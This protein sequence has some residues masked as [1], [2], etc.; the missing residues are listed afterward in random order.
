MGKDLEEAEATIEGLIADKPIRPKGVKPGMNKVSRMI[1]NRRL[2]DGMLKKIAAESGRDHTKP[3][4]YDGI[5]PYV[6][7]DTLKGMGQAVKEP[8]ISGLKKEAATLRRELR[9]AE[10]V[11]KSASKKRR[12]E[13]NVPFSAIQRKRRKRG[14]KR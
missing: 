6:I 9:E 5:D 8:T 7:E 14:K 3:D 2:S 1:S 13:L 12:S 11:Q 4:W 10:K